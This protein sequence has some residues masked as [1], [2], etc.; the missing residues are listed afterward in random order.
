MTPHSCEGGRLCGG[1]ELAEHS[2][3]GSPRGTR[4][5]RC[6]CNICFLVG[7]RGKGVAGWEAK[8]HAQCFRKWPEGTGNGSGRSCGRR[9]RAQGSGSFLGPDLGSALEVP[10]LAAPRRQSAFFFFFNFIYLFI[11]GCVGSSLLHAGF[12][13]LLRA[14]ATLCCGA[15]ASHCG[16]FSCCRA[17]ALGARASVVVARRLSSCGS[18]AQLLRG[19]WGLP[20]PGLE[21]LSPA[22]AG[23][24][25]TTAPPGKSP[26]CVLNHI[27]VVMA[28]R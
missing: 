6:V 20:G 11:F 21:P 1:S 5:Q 16:G 14:G 28:G 8:A 27:L 12:L 13:Q 4:C 15:W 17:Q 10:P 22:L 25:L 19:M 26:E 3:A 24:F 7:Q 2:R 9:V 18:R 23:R